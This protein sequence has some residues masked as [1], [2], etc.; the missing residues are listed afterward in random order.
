MRLAAEILLDHLP[1]LQAWLNLVNRSQVTEAGYTGV[2]SQATVEEHLV[3]MKCCWGAR[4]T[5]LLCMFKDT[6]TERINFPPLQ[7]EAPSFSRHQTKEL[8]GWD[9]SLW[10]DHIIL[11]WLSVW[12]HSHFKPWKRMQS[13]TQGA[14]TKFSLFINKNSECSPKWSQDFIKVEWEGRHS[15]YLSIAEKSKGFRD[16][17]LSHVVLQSRWRLNTRRGHHRQFFKILRNVP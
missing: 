8:H 12:V 17:L 11:R 14:H 10:N 4:H 2:C 3:R 15:K 5:D 13:N 1:L 7:P 9:F 6:R 16:L